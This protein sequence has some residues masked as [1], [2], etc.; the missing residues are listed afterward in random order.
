MG[1]ENPIHVPMPTPETYDPRT[2][3][4]SELVARYGEN[5]VLRAEVTTCLNIM[6][7]VG[8]VKKQEFMDIMLRQLDT[9]E[10]KRRAQANLDEDRG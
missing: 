10:Q 1:K 7:M 4:R 8:M 6:L 3:K 5:T 2:V 9:I